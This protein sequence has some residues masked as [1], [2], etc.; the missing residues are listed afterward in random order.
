MNVRRL[1]KMT[2]MLLAVLLVVFISSVASAEDHGTAILTSPGDS[3][4]V[5]RSVPEDNAPGHMLY[6]QGL[7]VRCLSDSLQDDWVEVEFGSQTGFVSQ[8]NLLVDQ[9]AGEGPPFLPVMVVAKKSLGAWLN[10]RAQRSL[11]SSV[12]G[13]YADGE[14]V[15]VYGVSKDCEWAQVGTADGK[16]GFMVPFYLWNHSP[17]TQYFVSER[18]YECSLR[19]ERGWQRVYLLG[20]TL[21]MIPSLQMYT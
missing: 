6:F 8:D 11:D 10:L 1:I 21:Q 19:M 15:K 4:V 16:Q 7:Q 5:W 12:L 17:L 9:F 14:L 20:K 3:M 2:C 18:V 13:Q